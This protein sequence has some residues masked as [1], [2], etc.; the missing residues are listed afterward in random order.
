MTASPR[1]FDL[2]GF[3]EAVQPSDSLRL[4]YAVRPVCSDDAARKHITTVE[5][6][7]YLHTMSAPQF[8]SGEPKNNRPFT[9][10]RNEVILTDRLRSKHDESRSTI[11]NFMSVSI[12]KDQR[13]KAQQ[14]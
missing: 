14:R 3:T 5:M 11:P 6:Y 8:E 4:S 1:A 12:T 9:P 2:H 10:I 7:A 13:R